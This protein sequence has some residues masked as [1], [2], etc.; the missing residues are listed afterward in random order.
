MNSN[1]Q[2]CTNIGG[3]EEEER[4]FLDVALDFLMLPSD[5]LK[6]YSGIVWDPGRDCGRVLFGSVILNRS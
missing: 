1:K 2:Y 4:V 5:L 6:R 3:E